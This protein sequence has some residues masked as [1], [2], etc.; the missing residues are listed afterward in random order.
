MK[1]LLH[2]RTR[3]GS[4]APTGES[5]PSSPSYPSWNGFGTGA[6]CGATTV[7]HAAD[8]RIAG[9]RAASGRM[10]TTTVT[11]RRPPETPT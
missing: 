5:A 9:V 6:T 7:H 10:S 8:G 4:F 3:A 2:G 1:Q 11:H